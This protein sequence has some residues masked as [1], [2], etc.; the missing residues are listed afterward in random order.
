MGKLFQGGKSF[1]G[2]CTTLRASL[3]HLCVLPRL[4]R[5]KGCFA[6]RYVW[7][8]TSCRDALQA[9]SDTSGL[10]CYEDTW[11]ALRVGLRAKLRAALWTTLQIELRSDARRTNHCYC[12]TAPLDRQMYNAG[13]I[14]MEMKPRAPGAPKVMTRLGLSGIGRGLLKSATPL[15]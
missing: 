1:P 9:N 2:G 4:S 8:W 6:V 7:S 13:Y 12:A 15:D 10:Q 3:R 11:A 5:P 14:H